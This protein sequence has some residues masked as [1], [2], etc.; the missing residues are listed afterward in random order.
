MEQYRSILA[1]RTQR[2]SQNFRSDSAKIRLSEGKTKENLVFFVFPNRWSS[3]SHHACMF[4]RVVTEEN[5]VNVSTFDEVKG[6]IKRGKNQRKAC[7]S[8]FF[9]AKVP[10]A[11]PK[12][13]IS[14]H[15]TKEK[16]F[17]L[18]F[19]R[20]KVP[21]AKPMVRISERKTK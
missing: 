19:C 2:R 20:A 5:K 18:L 14:E 16:A 21:S 12:V 1:P 9:R 6:T 13:R 8:L 11:K 17:F 3:E 4:G 15:R 7:F 10:S